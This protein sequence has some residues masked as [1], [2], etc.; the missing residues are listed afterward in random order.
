MGAVI[1]GDMA[2]SSVGFR[3]YFVIPYMYLPITHQRRP[4][5]VSP[6]HMRSCLQL[7]RYTGRQRSDDS[8][9]FW[10]MQN[11]DEAPRPVGGGGVV[12]FSSLSKV[13]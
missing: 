12:V 8:M 3:L 10:S 7:A 9:A 2:R 13:L 1:N 11:F 6:A 4:V 5:Y